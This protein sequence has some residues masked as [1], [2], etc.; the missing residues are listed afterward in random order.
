MLCAAC[1]SRPFQ[2][3]PTPVPTPGEGP[4]QTAVELGRLLPDTI[5]GQQALKRAYDGE[6]LL[7]GEQDVSVDDQLLGFIDRLGAQPDTILFA[8]SALV[9]RDE[10]A[11]GV[12]AFRLIGQAEEDLNAEFRVVMDT[13]GA[14]V[15]WEETTVGGKDVLRAE[16][17]D[18]PGNF[19]HL[20]TTGDLIFLV[21]AADVE[22][23]G[24][25]L[26]DLP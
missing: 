9:R 25:I 6:Q 24:D 17:P 22:V 12:V 18:N 14:P 21:T 5:R 4:P 23:A 26:E 8:F 19:M 1:L 2:P 3:T 15:V 16:D 13:P 20:Y 11:A 10:N 7:S